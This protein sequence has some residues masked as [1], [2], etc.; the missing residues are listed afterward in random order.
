MRQ[1]VRSLAVLIAVIGTVFATVPA[2]GATGVTVTVT[3]GNAPGWIRFDTGGNAVDAHDGEIKQFGKTYYLYGTSYGCG[4]VRFNGAGT[5]TNPVTPFCGFVAYSSTDLRHWTYRGQLFDPNSTSPTNWQQ[6]CNSATNSCYRPHMLYDY[7]TKRYVL[8]VN[9]YDTRDG[10]QHGYHVL[11]STNPVSGFTESLDATGQA[12]LPTLAFPNGGDLDLFQDNDAAHTA[13]IAYSV[14]R[15]DPLGGNYNYKIVVEQLAP[16]YLTGTGIYSEVGTRHSEAPSIFKRG[17]SYYMTF[18]DP[19]CAYC[20]GTGTSYFHA[21]SPLGP[22]W[23]T[24]PI[25]SPT[26]LTPHNTS[27]FLAGGAGM[28]TGTNTD[29][30]V[31]SVLAGVRDTD[32]SFVAKPVLDNNPGTVHYARVGWMFRATD[33][34]NGYLWILSNKPYGKAPA[35][36]YKEVLRNGAIIK[37]WTVPIQTPLPTT[38]WT[39]IRT[40]MIG[41][42]FY[43]Y[44]NGARVDYS[45]DS[46]YKTGYVGLR[47]RPGDG[48]YYDNI[49]EA[50]PFFMGFQIYNADNFDTGSIAS[51]P[52]LYRFRRHGITLSPNSCGGQPDDVAQLAAPN[53]TGSEYLY[54]SDRW[55]NADQ[56]EAQATQYWEPLKFNANGSIQALLCGA[57][58]TVT[59]TNATASGALP[60]DL[61]PNGVDGFSTAQDITAARSRG[62]TFSVGTQSNLQSVTLTLFQGDDING[63]APNADLNVAVYAIDGNG[64]PVGNALGTAVVPQSSLSWAPQTRTISLGA[65]LAP[66]SYAIVLSTTSTQGIYGT[67]RS[68][69]TADTFTGGAGLVGNVSSDGSST[70]W[71][72][73]PVNDLR[74]GVTMQAS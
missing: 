22:W 70:T 41:K 50:R 6:I 72:P 63:H 38:T 40:R 57:T 16:G 26:D 44:V 7:A 48:A 37:S 4:Y 56:N 5:N 2:A 51:F 74:F 47:E 13:Y 69:G 23:G 49:S 21:S 14:T 67:A 35:R 66:G 15:G 53:A 10:V 34:N 46:T 52:N 65:P 45:V 30:A 43:T 19:Y 55:D 24:G 17:T 25:V 12:A 8:W 61:T 68:D 32:V 60:L 36:L 73:E 39:N 62:E 29:P 54:Q 42:Q 20:A 11:T 33:P 3:N 31:Q 59:L 71:T 27:L 64:N 28:F 58:S 18:S 1:A 9:T